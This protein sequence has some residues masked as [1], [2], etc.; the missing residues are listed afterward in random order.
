MISK[1]IAIS[2][3]LLCSSGALAKPIDFT[4]QIKPI[5]EKNCI[6]CH[7]IEKDKGDLRLH[8][9]KFMIEGDVVEAGNIKESYLV[10]LISLDHDDDDIMPPKGKGEPLTKDQITLIKTWI[11]EGAKWPKGLEL[12]DKAEPK[13]EVVQMKAK[14]KTFEHLVPIIN[15]YCIECHNEDKQKGDFRIDNMDQDLVH[16]I[17]AQRWYEV[18]DIINLGEMPPKKADQ[19]H[20]KERRLMIETLTA[21]LQKAKE[22]RKGEI[23]TVMRRLNNDQYNNT[24]KDLL[25]IDFDFA[26]DLPEDAFS[27]EGFK[28]NGDTL[29]VSTLQMEY[30][31]DITRKALNK[32]ISSEKEPEIMNFKIDFGSSAN[33]SHREQLTMGPGAQLIPTH[34]YKVSEPT[35]IHKYPFIHRKLKTDYVFSE[36]YKGNSTVKGDKEF[37]GLFHAVYP[38]MRSNKG[39]V[40]KEGVTLSPRGD[41]NFGKAGGNGPSGQMKLVLRDYPRS[42]P[43]TIRVKASMGPNSTFM[44]N[45]NLSPSA[46]FNEETK[47]FNGFSTILPDLQCIP[48]YPPNANMEKPKFIIEDTLKIEKAGHYQID[49]QLLSELDGPINLRIGKTLLQN[50]KVKKGAQ[51]LIVPIAI[52]NLKKG[53][54]NIQITAKTKPQFA[55]FILSPLKGTDGKIKGL[56]KATRKSKDL[57]MVYKKNTIAKFNDKTGTFTGDALAFNISPARAIKEGEYELPKPIDHT[58]NHSF[59]LADEGGLY[60]VELKLQK[61]PSSGINIHINNAAIKNVNFSYKD[62]KKIYAAGLIKLSKGHQHL[63]IYSRHDIPVSDVLLTKVSNLQTVQEFNEYSQNQYSYLRPYIGNRRDDGQEFRIVEQIQKVNAPLDSPQV[64]EFTTFIDDYPLPAYDPT[65]KNYLANLLHLG[66]W[67]TPWNQNKNTDLVIHSI[68]F[69]SNAHKTWPSAQQK[70]IFIESKNSTNEALYAKEILANFLPKAFR[71]AISEEELKRHHKFWTIIYKHKKDFNESIKETLAIA[72]SSPQFLYINEP[73]GTRSKQ[74][75]EYE[76][77]SRLSYFL[78]NTMPDEELFSAASN[79]TL[80]RD[81]KQQIKRMIKDPRSFNFSK[82]FS[83][84]WLD[85][86]RLER[87]VIDKKH[88]NGY[89]QDIKNSFK[90]ETYSFFQHVLQN[91]FSIM[92]FIDSDYAILDWRLAQFY[93]LP[94]VDSLGFTATPVEAKHQRGGIITNGGLLTALSTGTHSSP[95]KRGVWLARKLVDSPPPKPPPNV[96]ALDEE[97]AALAKLTIKEQLQL[98]RD[99]AACR[100]CHMKIDPWGLPFE[101]YDTTGRIKAPSELIS[102]DTVFPDGTEVNGLNELKAYL[103]NEK[104]DLVSRSLVRH[105]SAYAM[106]RSLSFADD[107]E[108]KAILKDAKSSNYQIHSIIESIVKSDLFL[109][110]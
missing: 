77:A 24:L 37:K 8:T 58:I 12:E 28:N 59:S 103:I 94:P 48:S 14:T 99:K 25:G 70:K 23:S 68:E 79:G 86:E 73:E 93:N 3:A 15:Q 81:I 88:S 10:D 46:S 41:L 95:I 57:A 1:K 101:H 67:N 80:H 51:K 32:V 110:F 40:I 56:K 90:K 55:H 78:W 18:L 71:R 83:S 50:I 69:E 62:D 9:H 107:Y 85:V 39:K 82:N 30:Y 84:E 13:G 11:A 47:N 102:A 52:S 44:K 91:N 72:L 49:A 106:G 76:L 75:T 97:N 64:Y 36:G 63:H 27:P 7:G 26:R 38:E 54:I 87:V 61:K 43:I 20:D 105:L 100:D 108:I 17:H 2:L 45:T 29:D 42:G 96:P 35:P 4:T 19:L 104:A 34:E 92:N 65:N 5:L 16:G 89:N 22:V 109:K 31:L 98:H 66:F 60:Q 53:D 6:A 74:L 33:P 21:E